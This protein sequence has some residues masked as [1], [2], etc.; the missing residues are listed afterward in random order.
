[1]KPRYPRTRPRF[2]VW[3]MAALALLHWGCDLSESSGPTVLS[4]KLDD[5]LSVYDSIRVDILY[6][7]GTPYREAVFH[8]KYVPQP[9]HALN[10]LD[11]G[12]SPPERYQVLI[13]AY[14][15]AARALVYGVKVGP[16]GAE[17]PKVLVRNPGTG[18]G[19]G[20][21]EETPP[22][23]VVFLVPSPLALAPGGQAVQAA[24]EVQ[25]A[26]ADRGLAWS[27]SDTDVVR[28]D[29]GGMLF[30]GT[31]GQ[32]EITA[33]SLRDTALSAV[34]RVQVAAVN[35]IKGMSL[36]PDRA[37]LYVGGETLR[38][39]ARATPA[40]AQADLAYLSRDTSIAKV[41]ATGVIT[42]V[43]P[44]A[45]E[46]MAFPKGDVSLALP[47]QVTVKRDVPVLEIGGDRT[48][49][50]GDTLLFPVK[51]TQEYGV[52]AALK[53]DLDGD[54]IWDDSVAAETAM[55]RR[56]YDGKDTLRAAI[57]QVR[58]GEGNVAQAFVFVRVGSATRLS[59]P[60]FTAGTTPSPTSD[61]RPTWKWAGAAGGT[62]RYRI[63]LDGGPERETRDT[64]F[65]ADSLRDG[66]H[67]LSLR[68]LDA[69]GSSSPTVIRVIE[70]VRRGPAPIV[71][72][73]P[74]AMGVAWAWSPAPGSPGIGVYRFRLFAQGDWS[75][76]TADTAYAR[77][78][79]GTGTFSL[80]VEERDADGN[81][82]VPGALTQIK[83]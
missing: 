4:L 25:P 57:F 56:A 36:A 19:D 38:L 74:V 61:P 6:Q 76:E 18:S 68:E 82:S 71:T 43:A 58:D 42:A 78:D 63:A 62:G 47:C 30:P 60:A 37:L 75:P 29:G 34:L 77:A 33:R 54:G 20:G 59:P 46:V 81:W 44:G 10:D 83:Y 1:M 48:A 65:T 52:I 50:P 16:Q 66:A 55:P 80:E 72:V 70:V 12:K 13:T 5:S 53:W 11:L 3:A 9:D 35:R 32:A 49:R 27:S 21:P 31:A 39:D 73:L 51:A 67:S 15:D 28:V 79:L 64:A 2:A 26:G 69:F 7:D 45:V 14:R 40:E 23:R 8:G 41:S 17:A 24:A 22:L